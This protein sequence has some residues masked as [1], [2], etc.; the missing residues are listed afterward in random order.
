MRNMKNR[1][2]RVFPIFILLIGAFICLSTTMIDKDKYFEIFR[3]IELFTNIYKE[4]NANY[5][6]D[7]DPNTLMRT[8]ID[9]MMNSLDPYTTYYSEAQVESYRLSVDGKYNGLGA[10]SESIDGKEIVTDLSFEGPAYKAGIAVGDVIQSINGQNT[11]GRSHE[12]ILQFIRGYPGTTIELGVFRPNEDKSLQFRITRSEVDQ[13]NVPYHGMLDENIG[14]VYLTT[15]TQDAGKNIA[16]AIREMRDEKEMKA[17]ILDLRDNG[18]GLLSEAIDICGIFLPKGSLVVTTKGKIIERDQHYHTTR[19]PIDME[20]PVVVMTNKFSAS[21][22]EIVS[23]TLQDYDRAVILGQRTY[24]KGLVQN[25]REVGYN[26]R[27]KLTISKYFIPSGR[28]IQ[29]VAYENGEPKDIPDNQ[30][31][32]FKTRNGR[33]VLDG[34]GVTPD[35]KILEPKSPE[36]LSVLERDKWIFKYVNQYIHTI[37]S[38]SLETFQFNDFEGFIEFLT[39]NKFNY[40]SEAER[41]LASFQKIAADIPAIN[42]TELKS[43]SDKILAYKQKDLNDHKEEIVRSLESEIIGREYFQRGKTYHNL[44]TDI[45]ISKAKEILRDRLSYD[46]ILNRAE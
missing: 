7:L 1:N 11:S 43:L 8:G 32:I 45:E 41:S 28:C 30:R 4:L 16:R 12:D 18:G 23:G 10:T 25:T 35:I 9:A 22:S 46:K 36:I 13:P 14:Y 42:G 33:P 34:G 27:I 26:S 5:V 6:D 15:F 29:S 39:E 37:D 2:K 24:G 21:A 38:V 31:E 40:E 20:M 19:L 44:Q 17:L 3:N